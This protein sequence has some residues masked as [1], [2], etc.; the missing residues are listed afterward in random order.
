MLYAAWLVETGQ[1]L[2]VRLFFLPKGHTHILID[3]LFGRITVGCRGKTIPSV[4]DLLQVITDQM[5]KPRSRKYSFKSAESL[6]HTWNWTVFLRSAGRHPIGGM[7]TSEFNY[8]GY[9]DILITSDSEGKAC[10]RCRQSSQ[11]TFYEPQDQPQGALI[12]KDGP[13]TGQ[14]YRLSRTC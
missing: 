6:Q 11:S 8:G 12:W 3:Q 7:N 4:P 1:V 5:S 13:P 2:R 10:F 9:H 14:V